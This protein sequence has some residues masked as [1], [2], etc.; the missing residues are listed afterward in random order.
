MEIWQSES[1]K[2][3]VEAIEEGRIVRVS[4]NYAEKEGLLILKK[5]EMETDEK[6]KTQRKKESE[7]LYFDALRKP[8]RPNQVT[9]ELIDNFHW[10]IQKKRREMGLTRKQLAKRINEPEA[11]LKIIENGVIPSNDFII[12]NKLQDAL[13]TNLRKD[14]IDFSESP[15]SLLD[16]EKAEPKKETLSKIQPELIGEEIEL[17][18]DESEDF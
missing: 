15:R 11:N 2:E 12:I 6:Q 10:H 13:K 7:T 14:K 16:K 1:N 8:L 3:M 18:E 17:I 4:R 9:T 5:T